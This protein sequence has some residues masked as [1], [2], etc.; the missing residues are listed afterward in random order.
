MKSNCQIIHLCKK[1]EFNNVF[2]LSLIYNVLNHGSGVQPY[3]TD[4][5]A[6]A[7]MPISERWCV[8]SA[9]LPVRRK[10]KLSNNFRGN[11]S[12]T[13]LAMPGII[14]IFVFHYIPYFGLIL[15]F[16]NY[17]I[18]LGFWGS[19][20]VG[21]SNFRFLFAGDVLYR[22]TRNTILYNLV[23]IFFGTFCSVI[24]ALLLFELGRRSV[25]VFQTILFL[26]YFISWV[27][28][29][30]AFQALLNMD[31]GVFN[32]LL[33]AF[34]MDIILWYN[35]AKYWP[36]IIVAAAVW[37]GLGYGSVIFYAALMGIDSEY[38]EAATIDGAGKLRQTISISIPLIKNVIII[39]II[40]QIGRIFYSDFGLFY[41]VPMNSPLLYPTTDVIETFVF[42]AL[43][44]MGDI[45]MASAAG[46]YQAM[47]GFI[48]VIITNAVVRKVSAESALF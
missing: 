34:G 32:K 23:F 28:V 37:K 27:V 19:E 9:N 24:T 17:K 12:L 10:K 7:Q 46:F 26:P 18:N 11:F 20:W 31:Y 44:S 21:L 43:T 38:F 39:M 30:Y 2:Y 4:P 13:L 29:S 45:G 1:D 36:F 8:M 22:I 6:A 25:K 48:L 16:K 5:C 15:P 42:R 3:V 35:D 14:L 41:S 47:V 40:L 33:E